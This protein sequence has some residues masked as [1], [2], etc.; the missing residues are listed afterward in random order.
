[1]KT[2][3]GG[4]GPVDPEF[5][6]WSAVGPEPII[7][8]VQK[9]QMLACP[10]AIPMIED[11][12]LWTGASCPGVQRCSQAFWTHR[13]LVP[14]IVSGKSGAGDSGF[15]R[16]SPV[17]QDSTIMGKEDGLRWVGVGIPG[18][19]RKPPMGQLPP[20]PQI[21]KISRWVG[22]T[23]KRIQSQDRCEEVIAVSEDILK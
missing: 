12:L 8:G 13:F 18:V 6:I 23:E 4:S 20:K 22:Y 7:Q 10:P 11:Y 15:Q 16:L 3:T 14:K 5:H 1:M 17:C 21:V 2:V 9:G 19:R